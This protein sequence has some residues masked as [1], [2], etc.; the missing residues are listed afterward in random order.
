MRKISPPPG[1]DPRAVEAVASRY[2]DRATRPTFLHKSHRNYIKIY[3][4]IRTGDCFLKLTRRQNLG[5][6]EIMSLLIWRFSHENILVTSCSYHFRTEIRFREFYWILLW[7]EYLSRFSDW[8]SARRSWI[9]SR[10]G[11]DFPPVKTGPVAHQAS[12]KMGTGSFPG[13]KCGLGMLLTTHPLLVPRSWESRAVHLPTLWATPGL[14]R[15]HF[16]F[17]FISWGIDALYLI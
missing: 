10:W 13:L 17:T 4:W 16:T 9:E 8:L 6:E 1:F 14:L 7:A 5:G 12:C 2:N 11:R 15:D 3:L